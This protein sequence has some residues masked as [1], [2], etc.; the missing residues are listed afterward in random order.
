MLTLFLITCS[1]WVAPQWVAGVLGYQPRL[2]APWFEV[3]GQP[4]YKPWRLFQ[5]WYAYDAY[6]P[7]VFARA[8]VI[9]SL[10]GIAGIVMAVV[11]SLW[12]GGH[13]RVMFKGR[14]CLVLAAL[15][16][17]GSGGVTFGMQAQST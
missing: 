5:W 10:G 3:A 8:G 12:R 15:C 9:A 1:V 7:N 16:W 11:A 2:G 13:Q 14:A 17:G 4:F 6:A